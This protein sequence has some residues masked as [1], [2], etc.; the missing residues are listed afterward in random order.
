MKTLKELIEEH[1]HPELAK[2]SGHVYQVWGDGEITLTKSGDL[3]GHRGL[4]CIDKGLIPEWAAD[5]LPEASGSNTFIYTDET[6]ALAVRERIWADYVKY[7]NQV[8]F[9]RG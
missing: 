6:G 7:T 3:L 2:L 1:N 8:I 5:I 9:R 4:H